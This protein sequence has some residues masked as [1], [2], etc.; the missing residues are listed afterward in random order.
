[1]SSGLAIASVTAVLKHVLE[2]GLAQ[3]HI[4]A[5][6]G[7]QVP[8]TALPPDRI[9]VGADE[10]PQLNLF[11]YQ[12]TPNTGRQASRA[13]RQTNGQTG[14]ALDLYYLVTAYCASDFQAEI[15]LGYSLQLLHRSSM[16]RDELGAALASLSADHDGRG[17]APSA[18]ALAESNLA[19]RVVSLTIT[20]QFPSL[21]ELSKLW[22]S[23]QARFRPSSAYKVSLVYS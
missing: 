13:E 14:L 21:E 10:Q 19:E 1:M 23:L 11:L 5:K 9:T 2:N 12:F 16:S 4:S 18:A 6:I 17:V 22:S 7:G 8:V 20:P 3:Q 15:L